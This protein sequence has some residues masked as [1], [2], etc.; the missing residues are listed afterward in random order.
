[1]IRFDFTNCQQKLPIS[2][3]MNLANVIWGN[4]KYPTFLKMGKTFSHTVYK[5]QYLIGIL[6]LFFT[7]TLIS[8]TIPKFTTV[9]DS[10]QTSELVLLDR[11]GNPLHEIRNN[12]MTR[13]TNWVKLENISSNVIHSLLIAEDRHFFEHK[14]VDWKALADGALRYFTFRGKRGAS[15]IT[16]QLASILDSRLK[17]KTG[18]RTI[19]QKWNQIEAAQKLE[20]IW[21]KEEDEEVV[22][23]DVTEMPEA[24]DDSEE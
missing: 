8:D 9:K 21:S 17:G 24:V 14:G 7:K 18:G 16:M 10:I 4:W 2:Y 1:M 12:K 5:K 15:T 3:K 23:P 6:F 19:S 22:L 13:R 11:N 20:E